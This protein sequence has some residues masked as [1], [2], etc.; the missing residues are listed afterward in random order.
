MR[1]QRMLGTKT[2]ELAYLRGS[3]HTCTTQALDP[4]K[5]HHFGV[6]YGFFIVQLRH[7]PCILFDA[8]HS[9]NNFMTSALCLHVCVVLY[10]VIS[11]LPFGCSLQLCLY[12]M[13]YSCI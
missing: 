2:Q 4:N 12:I 8:Y 5:V 10:A 9:L 6:L 1:W 7:M 11:M 3:L 13:Y